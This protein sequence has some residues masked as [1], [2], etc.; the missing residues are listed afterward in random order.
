[1]IPR[2]EILRWLSEDDPEA[3]RELR[4]RADAVR[5]EH[6]GEAVHLR[7]LVEISNHCR[8]RCGYC[9]LSAERPDLPRYRM[10][11]DEILAAAERAVERGYGTVV[12]QAGEDP[13]LEATWVARLIA[14][15]KSELRL[16]VTLSLGERSHE[17]LQRWRLAGADRYLLRFETSHAA[18]Y[19]RIH[20]PAENGWRDRFAVLAALRELDYEVGSGVM[21]GIPGQD[22]D[23]LATDIERFG[24]LELDM[25]GCG[26]YIPHPD[27]PLGRA[28][29]PPADA[30]QTPSTAAFACRV[31][32]LARLVRPRSNIPATTAVATLDGR[33]GYEQALKSGANVIMP[34]LTPAEYRRQYEIYPHKAGVQQDA[35]YHV[36]LKQRIR[37]MGRTVGS[38]RGDS[39][40]YLQRKHR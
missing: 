32:A 12:L 30:H 34:N 33:S 31:L 8:R 24:E 40:A 10:S 6:V 23:T 4:G 7:A 21:I 3:L 16:A 39:P 35:A 18:L 38:G 15:L 20:P 9:G 11:E 37:A 28:P 2:R 36:V 22:L 5:R 13:H 27:T 1:M 14:R 26:P 29:L 19:D 25:I 17:D